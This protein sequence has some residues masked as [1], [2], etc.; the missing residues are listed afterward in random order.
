METVVI[1]QLEFSADLV[2]NLISNF[3]NRDW[4]P[5]IDKVVVK[6]EGVGAIR[7]MYNV[8]GDKPVAERLEVFDDQN[9]KMSYSIVENSPL[10]LENFLGTVKVDVTGNNSCQVAWKAEGI[11][12]SMSENEVSDIMQ[13]IYNGIITAVEIHLAK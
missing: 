4:S 5:S 2:W 9:M 1:R 6:G 7:W 13:N 11:E 8:G 3:G 12:K 10:P